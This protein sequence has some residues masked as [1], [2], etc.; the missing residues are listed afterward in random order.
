MKNPLE[1][2]QSTPQD[3]NS[4]ADALGSSDPAERERTREAL[5]AAGHAAIIPLLIKLYSPIDHVCWEAAK[6]LCAIKDPAAADALVEVLDHENDEVRWVAAQA[7]IALG[8]EGLKQTLYALL[9][10]AH[11]IDVRKG[12]HH[13]VAH[14]AQRMS[15]SFLKPLLASFGGFEPAVEIPL[16]AL[17]ALHE[18]QQQIPLGK[19]L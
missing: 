1:T 5:V 4:L 14:F 7:L 9:T 15:G 18:L 16:A 11:S 12:A 17:N 10:K 13:V 19:K 2:G 3:V 8:P 6:A